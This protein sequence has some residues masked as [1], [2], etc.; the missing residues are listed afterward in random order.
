MHADVNDGPAGPA[1]AERR[2]A[3]STRKRTVFS[4]PALIVRT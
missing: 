3:V 1:D 4:F 2:L